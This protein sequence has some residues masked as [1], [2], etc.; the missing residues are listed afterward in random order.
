[1]K[2]VFTSCMDAERVPNQPIWDQIRNN[3]LP[4]VL[5]LIGDQIY[6][7]WGDLGISN[8]KQAIEQGG[9]KGEKALNAFA[10]DMH[11]RYASQ[12]KVESFRKLICR[13][14]AQNGA[15]NLLVCWDDH[16]FAWNNAVGS[17]G[18]VNTLDEHQV[19]PQVKAISMMLFTQF[20]ATL[21]AGKDDP[22][23]P[24][25]APRPVPDTSEN[26]L[27]E[28]GIFSK[29]KALPYALL[30]AR[31]NR[32]ERV[33]K[34][35]LSNTTRTKL[36]N[37][38][39]RENEGLMLII[40]GSPLAYKYKFSEQ[41]WYS[42]KEPSYND[43][44]ELLQSTKRPILYLG[45]DVHRNAWSGRL[46]DSKGNVSSVLQVLSSGAAIAN[47]GPKKFAPSYASINIEWSS[48]AAGNVNINLMS[49]GKNGNWNLRQTP[50]LK[51][52]ANIW[53]DTYEGE[54][55]AVDPSA[56]KE[57]LT[58]ISFYERS[59]EFKSK[60]PG[61]VNS[62]ELLNDV[63][64][65]ES[66]TPVLQ[67]WE[68]HAPTSA[69]EIEMKFIGT[70]TKGAFGPMFDSSG[71]YLAELITR[72]FE[73]AHN[74]KKSV[75]LY[76]H[77]IGHPFGSA[78]AQAYRLRETY[79]NCEPVVF[80]WP[81]GG[82]G[83]L[84]STMFAVPTAVKSAQQCAVAL[85]QVLMAFN[86]VAA[87]P[88]Y[89]GLT[90]VVAC[91]SAGSLV[92]QEAIETLE[93]QAKNTFTYIH[94]IIFSSSLVGTKRFLKLSGNEPYSLPHI[95]KVVLL[96]QNDRTL[97]LADKQ[98]GT[99]DMLGFDLPPKGT[100]K[101]NLF[102]DFTQSPG[103][104]SMH[105]YLTVDVNKAQHDVINALICEKVFYP[106]QHSNELKDEGGGIY[107]VL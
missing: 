83:G 76:I 80:A 34:K 65:N 60:N 24:T 72:A 77:G 20:R 69:D 103:V 12:W 68:I 21:R 46:R 94:R 48:A 7:D 52:D 106:S 81:A 3:D 95:Q 16:D 79:P 13:F 102:L 56:D 63:F 40:G 37:E 19:P 96:N 17:V 6:M 87:L 71:P 105:D 101:S 36:K 107:S 84:L 89:N 38:I 66:I 18:N 45:G 82:S 42:E 54:A 86:Y 91:R 92:L 61:T 88:K 78:V 43:Y 58:A 9:K 15:Q 55:P 62:L 33:D 74:K 97:K 30:D 93:K 26:G 99:G 32:T 57:P 22:N 47:I 14:V 5:M 23:Y 10:E 73:R 28:F 27:D 44:D 59:K 53:L 70:V 85:N 90:K 67:Y 35:M 100:D 29:G 49:L 50:E 51:F 11:S 4:D 104:L 41:A 8:W 98:D 1:M 31:W 39:G 25:M 2:I 75:M 64:E